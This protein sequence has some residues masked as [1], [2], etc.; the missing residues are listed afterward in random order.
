M[1]NGWAIVQ[2]LGGGFRWVAQ[3]TKCAWFSTCPAT[4]AALEAA[5]GPPVEAAFQDLGVVQDCHGKAALDLQMERDI[6][7]LGKLNQSQSVALD[8]R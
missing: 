4:R 1:Q 3:T 7:A 8:F 6:K 2:R 5:P